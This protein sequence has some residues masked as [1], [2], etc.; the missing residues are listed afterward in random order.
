MR[1]N[2]QNKKIQVVEDA[3]VVVEMKIG[4]IIRPRIHILSFTEILKATIFYNDIEIGADIEALLGGSTFPNS[5]WVAWAAE[6]PTVAGDLVAVATPAHFTGADPQ[7]A[8]RLK[9]SVEMDNVSESGE[10]IVFVSGEN[11]IGS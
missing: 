6:T 10:I 1:H 8:A 4:D 2:S 9:I 7:M 11:R 3:V 5:K